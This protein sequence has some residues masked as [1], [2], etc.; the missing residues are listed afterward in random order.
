MCLFGLF[1]SSKGLQVLLSNL[2]RYY[3]SADVTFFEDTPFFSPSMDYS[4]SLQQVL[5]VPS[6]CPLGNS[7]QNVS[8]VSSSP[9]NSTEVAPPPLITYQHKIQQ[10][11]STVLESSPRDSHLPPTDPQTMDPSSSTSSHHSDSDWPI[12]IKKDTRSTHNPHPIYNFLSYH[13]L[14]LSYFSFVSSLSSLTVPSNIHE[15]LDHPGQR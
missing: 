7:D 13:H 1:S 6:P 15:A 8:G 10:V 12:P 9:P 11:G 4:P 3:M 5:P 14:S 2:R